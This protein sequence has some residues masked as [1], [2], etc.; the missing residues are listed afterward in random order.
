[1][2]NEK[3][4]YQLLNVGLALATFDIEIHADHL[5]RVVRRDEAFER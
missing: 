1:M 2:V 4:S 3:R 5:R